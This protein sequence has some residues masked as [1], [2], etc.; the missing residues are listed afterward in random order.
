MQS[1][2]RGELVRGEVGKR[3]HPEPEGVLAEARL[4]VVAL[5]HRDVLGED[6]GAGGALGGAVRSAVGSSE[7]L[8]RRRARLRREDRH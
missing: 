7:F 2:A 6:G 3:P 1:L 4:G 5:D 8:E